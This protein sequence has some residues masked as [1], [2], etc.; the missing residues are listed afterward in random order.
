MGRPALTQLGVRATALARYQRRDAGHGLSRPGRGA[1]RQARPP[2]GRRQS[3]ARPLTHGLRPRASESADLRPARRRPA[4]V[5]GQ[6]AAGSLADGRDDP[7]GSGAQAPVP[8]AHPGRASAW[9]PHAQPRQARPGRP[10]WAAEGRTRPRAGPAP[11]RAERSSSG[12]AV[13]RGRRSG[14]RRTW[15][16]G[17][18]PRSSRRRRMSG[19]PRPTSGIRF[20]SSAGETSREPAFRS[21][22]RGAMRSRTQKLSP[23]PVTECAARRATRRPRRSPKGGSRWAA[24]G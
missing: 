23:D 17:Q 11:S 14:V 18:R 10:S 9:P 1:H 5:S 21:R 19:L 2:R 12:R 15:R 6:P 7:H 16:G 24:L 13:R 22:W 3:P 4:A 8:L 20:E